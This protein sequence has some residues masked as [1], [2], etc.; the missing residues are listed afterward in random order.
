MSFPYKWI[1][2]I[3]VNILIDHIPL[4]KYAEIFF[5]Y[6]CSL[7]AVLIIPPSRSALFAEISFSGSLA[8]TR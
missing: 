7:T 4:S 5:C 6:F 3:T 8:L 1:V 2:W